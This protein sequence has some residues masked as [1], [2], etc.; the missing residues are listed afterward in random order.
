M[1]HMT[2]TEAPPS[3]IKLLSLTLLSLV[4][5]AMLWIISSII[6]TALLPAN[7]TW[8]YLT[9]AGYQAPNAMAMPTGDYL[10][11]VTIL[12][13]SDFCWLYG[14]SRLIGLSRKFL[15]GDVLTVS[16]VTDLIH[17]GW[18][19]LASAVAE[20][21]APLAAGSLL[22]THGYL[23]PLR[24]P[25]ALLLNPEALIT[26]IGAMLVILVAQVFRKA[27][28]LSEEVRLTI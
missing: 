14:L 5:A 8:F 19:L 20:F 11:L 12:S 4:G 18:A 10:T 23:A 26:C 17:F 25:L 7:S 15:R 22:V 1:H 21:I 27:V 13:L 3:G 24:D 9:E 28:A 2:E 6:Y 16:G